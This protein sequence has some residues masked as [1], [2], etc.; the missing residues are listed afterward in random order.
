MVSALPFGVAQS[1]E[2]WELKMMGLAI[3]F[4][5]AFFKFAWSY[6]LYNYFAIMVGAAPPPAEKDT[7]A[8]QDFAHR[9]ARL[10]ADAGR[11]FNRGQ[12]AFFFALGYLG[13]FLGPAAAGAHHHRHRHRDVAPAIRLGFA[14]GVFANAADPARQ[15]ERRM[16]S[17]NPQIGDEHMMRHCFEL[18]AK[19]A[20]QGEYPYAAVIVREGDIVAETTNRV[21][22]ERDV[23]RHAETVAISLAQETLASTDL[24]DCTI[25]TNMEPC[26]FCCYAIRESRI[27]KVVFSMR[28]PVWAD[29]RAGIYLGDHKLSDTMPEVFA[30]PPV[31]LAEFLF[32][33]GDATLRR[34]S[35]MA[36]AFMRARGLLAP[37]EPQQ[38]GG[39]HAHD[40]ANGRG[41]VAHGGMA[42]ARIAAEFFRSV[43]AR[44]RASPAARRRRR[45]AIPMTT[46]ISATISTAALAATTVTTRSLQSG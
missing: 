32:E 16:H 22:H 10:C 46:A 2:M 34:S 41:Y 37:P 18:A 14:A 39:N 25:Y 36:W 42:S 27:G 1:Q 13:W 21:A 40:G 26:A 7:A 5:Y 44:R 33:E 15:A 31:L 17:P 3:I 24:S 29:R 38:A 35:P 11:H 45:H 9:A 8:A 6:R 28:S 20:D 19:S 12:R 23:T 4:V 30:P 43:R